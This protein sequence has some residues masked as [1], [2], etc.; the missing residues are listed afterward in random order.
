MKKIQQCFLLYMSLMGAVFMATGQVENIDK[1]A[2]PLEITSGIIYTDNL[3]PTLENEVGAYGIIVSPRGKLVFAGD[4][5][6]FMADYEAQLQRFK[7]SEELDNLDRDQ[8]FNSVR[9][10]LLSRFFVSDAWYIDADVQHSSETQRFGTGITSLRKNV[11]LADKLTSNNAGLKLVYGKDTSSRYISLKYN[12]Q[13]N[14]YEAINAYSELFDM[15]QQS[16]KFDLAFGQ[17]S[18]T[19]I[20]FRFELSDDDFES[21]LREDS[22]LYEALAGVNWKPSGKTQLE[23]YIGVYRREFASSATSTG[24]SWLL[25]FS[26]KPTDNWLFELSSARSSDVSKTETTSDTLDQDNIAHLSYL[27]SEQW[28]IGAYIAFVTSE[29]IEADQS[30]QLDELKAGLAWTLSVQ[31]YNQISLRLGSLDVSGSGDV[32]EY[33]QNEARIDWRYEF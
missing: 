24:L 33:S 31:K 18:L 6:W 3:N 32:L 19:R 17:S 5:L 14:D 30:S 22:Q 13:D 12:Y 29:F 2:S 26:H 4:G 20:L 11:T 1:N 21:E 27:Y 9:A 16:L 25:E 23:A 8:S 7:L 15:T 10:R 28:K